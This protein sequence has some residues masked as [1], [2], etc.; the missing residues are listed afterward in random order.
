MVLGVVFFWLLILGKF[1][2][3]SQYVWPAEGDGYAT[4]DTEISEVKEKFWTVGF[5]QQ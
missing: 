5:F 2:Q 4:T 3:T 1:E